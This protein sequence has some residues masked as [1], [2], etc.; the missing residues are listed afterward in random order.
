MSTQS[1]AVH[2]TSPADQVRSGLQ[3]HRDLKEVVRTAP[4]DIVKGM[5]PSRSTVIAIG[6]SSRGKTP[7]IVLLGLCIAAGIPFLNQPV[8]QGKVIYVDF[9]NGYAPMSSLIDKLL[10]HCGLDQAPDDFR[11]L[12]FPANTEQVKKAVR[13]FRPAL[14]IIDSLRGYNSQ[15][16]QDNTKA[17]TMLTELQ[18]FAD[19][20]GTTFLFIHH[21][22]KDDKKNPTPPL[23]D[24]PV[25]EWLQEAA[26]ARALINQ[27][28]V[29]IAIDKGTTKEVDLILKWRYKIQGEFGP[30]HIKRAFS[31]EG[32]PIGYDR[33]SG[34]GLLDQK[35]RD[36]FAKLPE[37]FSFGEAEKWTGLKRATLHD[38]LKRCTGVGVLE[39]VGRDKAHG[40]FYRK[41]HQAPSSRTND[42][43]MAA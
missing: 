17:G 5:V 37:H 9:E 39:K 32:E 18:R 33:L 14:V 16:E 21:I 42:E 2:T 3:T 4:G 29:Q 15:A 11:I 38:F 41:V 40:T 12:S 34:L 31:R 26:G 43:E 13:D 1:A 20:T 22:R 36:A 25:M 8:R 6:D 28:G 19:E 30:W 35:N 27:T 23:I 24:T 7:L 10:E